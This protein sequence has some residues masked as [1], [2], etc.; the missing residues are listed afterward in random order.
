MGWIGALART[1][2]LRA[3]SAPLGGLAIG[4]TWSVANTLPHLATLLAQ[5]T[6]RRYINAAAEDR[7]VPDELTKEKVRKHL[8]VRA[9]PRKL[10]PAV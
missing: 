2:G 3:L 4:G 9:L 1:S 6:G 5:Q 10:Q 8:K 7:H